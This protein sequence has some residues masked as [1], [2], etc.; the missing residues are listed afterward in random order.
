MRVRV[1]PVFYD[2]KSLR[3]LNLDVKTFA[4]IIKGGQGVAG[5]RWIGFIL[6]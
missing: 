1:K 2:K 6:F 4:K 3:R 5:H